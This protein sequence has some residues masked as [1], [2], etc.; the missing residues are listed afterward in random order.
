M[1]TSP[2]GPPGAHRCHCLGSF[3]ALCSPAGGQMGSPSSL[4]LMARGLRQGAQGPK[5]DRTPVMLVHH[6]RQAHLAASAYVRVVR[7]V[8]GVMISVSQT[9]P[10]G[11]V[12]GRAEEDAGPA[13]SGY[14]C[15]CG[16]GHK[17]AS[18]HPVP[19]TRTAPDWPQG[20]A[21]P[22]WEFV[23]PRAHFA[24]SSCLFPHLRP[25]RWLRAYRR[26][27]WQ[28]TGWEALLSGGRWAAGT[29]PGP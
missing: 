8:S 29:L 25:E 19:L 1:A 10:P 22:R 15:R 4:L 11:S 18:L 16:G 12:A 5:P 21:R 24:A 28:V 7:G 3:T 13:W 2:M 9:G 27:R 17:S 23:F 26:G 6:V 14:R 20:Q